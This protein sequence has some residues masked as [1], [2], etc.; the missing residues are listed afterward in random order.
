MSAK[1]DESVEPDLERGDVTPAPGEATSERVRGIFA[2][3]ANRYD[4]FN[5]LS[6]W[7]IDRVWRKRT[8][9]LAGIRKG[10]RV[11]DLCAGT[12]DLSL[13]IARDTEASEVVGSDFVPE[14]LEVAERKLERYEGRAAVSFCLVDAQDIPFD[15]ESF[16]V[17]TVAF[18]VRNL[19]DR[20]A[21]FS[22]VFRVL[23]PGGRYVILEFS[24]PI[25]APFRWFYHFYLRLV[26][27][28]LGG[29]LTGDRPSFQYLNDSIRRFPAQAALSAELREAGFTAITWH[30]LSFGIAAVHIATK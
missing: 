1:P 19:P 9:R 3:I 7:G 8:V 24:R 12:G 15:D 22:E 13:A 25:L 2:G 4:L 11:L 16:E 26:I 6:S 28:V 27:P 14:M 21:N 29:L 20:P 30:N 23:R 17:V 10:D 18:G 5:I